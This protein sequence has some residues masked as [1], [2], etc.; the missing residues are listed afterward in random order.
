MSLKRKRTDLSKAHV[1]FMVNILDC[2]NSKY[3]FKSSLKLRLKT[4]L[5]LKSLY[6]ILKGTDSQASPLSKF[7]LTGCSLCITSTE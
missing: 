4:I 6:G 5:D 1:A 2:K 3:I 7:L